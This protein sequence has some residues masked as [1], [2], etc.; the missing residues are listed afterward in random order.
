[1]LSLPPQGQRAK[2]CRFSEILSTFLRNPHL[3]SCATKLL[4][5]LTSIG[6]RWKWMTALLFSLKLTQASLFLKVFKRSVSDIEQGSLIKK[7]P[8]S[9]NSPPNSWKWCHKY[10]KQLHGETA[11][12]EGVPKTPSTLKQV[13]P[14]LRFLR[15]EVTTYNPQT[16]ILGSSPRWDIW[17]YNCLGTFKTCFTTSIHLDAPFPTL[18]VSQGNEFHQIAL[19]LILVSPGR[20]LVCFCIFIS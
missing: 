12:F 5:Y 2:L 10:Q 20:V 3:P 14:E 4:K 6:R 11:F 8:T 17:N 16:C 18:A 19:P 13:T 15:T 1:M 7:E 9:M